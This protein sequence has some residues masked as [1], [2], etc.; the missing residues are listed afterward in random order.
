MYYTSDSKFA[1]Q[2]LI[3][4]L[5]ING[6]SFIM[7]NTWLEIYD[8]LNYCIMSSTPEA[9]YQREIENCFKILG[10]RKTN[11]TLQSQVSIPIGNNNSIRPDIVLQYET[12][13]GVY[14]PAVAVE[15]KRPDNIK[16]ERQELQ[17]FSYM[18]QLRISFGLYIGEK[19]QLF[20]DAQNKE[21]PTA[22]PSSILTVNICETENDGETFCRLFSYSDFSIERLEEFCREALQRKL[23]DDRLTG[24]MQNLINDS[25]KSIKKLLKVMLTR[26]G[27]SE[28]KIDQELS[29]IS[30]HI[31]SIMSSLDNSE[32]N[33]QSYITNNQQRISK[34]QTR[35]TTRFSF[36]GGKTFFNKRKFVLEII[37][38][39]VSS[40]PDIS[41]DELERVFYP[42]IYNRHRGVIKKLSDVQQM[43]GLSGDVAQRYFMDEVIVLKDGTKLVVNNQW[44]TRFPNFLHAIKDIYN[45]VSDK[46]YNR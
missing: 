41:F 17:L 3:L 32:R 9:V 31:D 14:I 22:S 27:F 35:D 38:H 36:D 2:L 39:Y 30:I 21:N 12:K 28:S 34:P 37:K 20:Y 42:D 44:G 10:W 24:I 46:E 18:R 26:E 43:I 29:K 23:E 11:N 15:I 13:P 7:E 4:N 25:D 8:I 45:V 16:S 33:Y 5:R 40:H 1:I 6:T 19:I